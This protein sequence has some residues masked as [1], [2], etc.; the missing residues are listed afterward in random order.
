VHGR[1]LA[2]SIAALVSVCAGCSGALTPPFRQYL[3]SNAPPSSQAPYRNTGRANVNGE[4]ELTAVVAARE[5]R[6]PDISDDWSA[7]AGAFTFIF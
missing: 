6:P 7:I 3:T 4:I 1:P 5:A 2:F